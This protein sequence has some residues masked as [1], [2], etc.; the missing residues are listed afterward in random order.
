M[1][2][3]VL[4]NYYFYII[5]EA[6]AIAVLMFFVIPWSKAYRTWKTEQAEASEKQK[7]DDLLQK[8]RNEKRRTRA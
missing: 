6:I 2:Y 3:E 4:H 8:L 5:L 1:I 7:E